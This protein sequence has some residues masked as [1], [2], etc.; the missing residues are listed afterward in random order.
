MPTYRLKNLICA[1]DLNHESQVAMQLP[2]AT[3]LRVLE[4]SRELKGFV[5]VESEG[6]RF[7]VF[8]SD[9]NRSGERIH[10]R[11]KTVLQQYETGEHLKA[12]SAKA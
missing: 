9:L 6:L 11:A 10:S 7:A 1:V 2:A 12:N 8:L 4:P 3:V 5:S